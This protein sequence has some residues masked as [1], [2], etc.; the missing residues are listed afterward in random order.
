[1]NSR[2]AI[3]SVAAVV[4]L[5]IFVMTS[6]TSAQRAAERPRFRGFGGQRV[7]SPEVSEDRRITFRILAPEAKAVRLTGSDIPGNSRGAEMTKDANDIWQITLG[8]IEPGVR[9]TAEGVCRHLERYR[10]EIISRL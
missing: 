8:P 6:T 10:E 7:T 1:M 9:P 3:F 2:K 5:A 4:I